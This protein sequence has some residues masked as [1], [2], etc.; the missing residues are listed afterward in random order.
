MKSNYQSLVLSVMSSEV[1]TSLTINE[2]TVVEII[3][4]DSST[5]LGMTN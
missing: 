3:V 4:R 1:E 5:P 2:R